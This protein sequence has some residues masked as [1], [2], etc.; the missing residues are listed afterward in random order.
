VNI[1]RLPYTTLTLA[2]IML[3]LFLLAAA[4]TAVPQHHTIFTAAAATASPNPSS[5]HKSL[6]TSSAKKIHFLDYIGNKFESTAI[7]THNTIIQKAKEEFNHGLAPAEVPPTTVP[8]TTAS[9][10]TYN[11]TASVEEEASL[12]T[13]EGPTSETSAAWD[14]DDDVQS[15]Q[16]QE[17]NVDEAEEIISSPTQLPS[18]FPTLQVE[19]SS[20]TP[21]LLPVKHEDTNSS[22]PMVISASS[23]LPTEEVYST[24]PIPSSVPSLMPSQRT[25][26]SPTVDDSMAKALTS[27]VP[28]SLKADVGQD[29]LPAPENDQ[30]NTSQ[31]ED[32][33]SSVKTPRILCSILLSSSMV[34]SFEDTH[35]LLV[36]MTKTIHDIFESHLSKELYNLQG[37]SL[38]MST[39]KSQTDSTSSTLRLH[40]SFSGKASF[41]SDLA[42]TQSELI[43]LLLLH[44]DVDEFNDRLKFPLRLRTLDEPVVLEV[45]SVFF[46]VEDGPLVNAAAISSSLPDSSKGAILTVNQIQIITVCF[47]AAALPFVVVA[48]VLLVL[49]MRY[50]DLEEVYLDLE[51]EEEDD[52]EST[53]APVKPNEVEQE[54]VVSPVKSKMGNPET[55]NIEPSIN[56]EIDV[57]MT[58]SAN[59]LLNDVSEIQSECWSSISGSFYDDIESPSNLKMS[60]SSL[61]L[62]ISAAA[63]AAAGRQHYRQ[64]SKITP[65]Y[66]HDDYDSQEADAGLVS[67]LWEQHDHLEVYEDCIMDV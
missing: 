44:F 34:K 27:S 22:T 15:S 18:S 54:Q 37:I 29:A 39:Q 30:D 53:N 46:S 5:Y 7:A 21:T 32:V 19:I 1:L 55:T 58:P 35:V 57:P 66:A 41:S 65:Y 49:R 62:G 20:P 25:T 63:A 28:S 16:G 14:N 6:N 36:V 24:S 47:V 59:F 67:A 43:E 12:W 23:T 10:N 42:P 17:D 8:T 2:I 38:H 3:I 4:T 11:P 60:S 45:N 56:V 26:Q 51:A 13:T 52:E 61:G 9:W 48:G 40:A 50:I 31:D 64:Q 33:T